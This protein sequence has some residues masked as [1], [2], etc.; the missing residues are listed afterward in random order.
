MRIRLL[1]FLIIFLFFVVITKIVDLVQGNDMLSE[2]LVSGTSYAET[3]EADAEDSKAEEGVSEKAKDQ[4][5]DQK[6]EEGDKADAGKQGDE[7]DKQQEE[8]KEGKGSNKEEDIEDEEDYLDGF[9]EIEIEMLQQLAKRR[10][11]LDR[12]E[13]EIV[14]QKNILNA[15]VNK[16]D[17]KIAEMKS[18]KTE[19][20]ELLE[21]YKDKQDMN[22]AS[23]VKIYSSMKSKE[24][25]KIFE[26]LDMPVLIQVIDQMKE[27]KVAL[28]LA[29]MDPIKAKVL[30]VKLANT[31]KLS[32]DTGCACE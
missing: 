23:L 22:I 20:S 2:F 5:P 19:L 3:T 12:R 10:A 15:T 26:E 16:I 31:K 27:S 6:A 17:T 1:P 9:S 24:A 14:T 28:I 30:T 8:S 29:Q 13:Y 25:A 32:S 7:E 21:Q 18:L 11:D 4:A